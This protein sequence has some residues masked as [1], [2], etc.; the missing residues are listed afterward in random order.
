MLPKVGD[1][2]LFIGS[3]GQPEPIRREEGRRLAGNSG[4]NYTLY[5]VKWVLLNAHLMGQMNVGYRHCR[6]ENKYTPDFT[7]VEEIKPSTQDGT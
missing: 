7:A 1:P 2:E 6:E 4:Q 3:Q 5:M